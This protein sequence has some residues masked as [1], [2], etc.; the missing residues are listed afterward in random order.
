MKTGRNSY[1]NSTPAGLSRTRFPPGGSSW[2][3]R[4]DAAGPP[5]KVLVLFAD[6]EGRPADVLPAFA[7]FDRNCPLNVLKSSLL[8]DGAILPA[9]AKVLDPRR[10]KATNYLFLQ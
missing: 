4:R 1:S 3:R 5:R 9:T 6:S 2:A 7:G 8:L 10:P